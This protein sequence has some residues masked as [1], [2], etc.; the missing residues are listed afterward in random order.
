MPQGFDEPF[1]DDRFVR[2]VG[3]AGAAGSSAGANSAGR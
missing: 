3:F 2:F 1:G